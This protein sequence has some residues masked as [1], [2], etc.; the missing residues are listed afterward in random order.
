M[1]DLNQKK[2][3]FAVSDL[4]PKRYRGE[5]YVARKRKENEALPREMSFKGR[6]VYVIGDG[7]FA[8]PMRPGANDHLKHKSLIGSR[9]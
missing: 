4:A 3:T 2:Q 9:K 6:P 8:I 7:D 1:K 5:G